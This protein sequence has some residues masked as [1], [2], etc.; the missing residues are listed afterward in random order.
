MHLQPLPLRLDWKFISWHHLLINPEIK[1]I[2][3]LLWGHYLKKF[4]TWNHQCISHRCRNP[5]FVCFAIP[6]FC[7]SIKSNPHWLYSTYDSSP[8][9]GSYLMMLT[10]KS[11]LLSINSCYLPCDR[12]FPN[13]RT[14]WKILQLWY[15][16]AD[17]L[18]N[19][20]VS[21]L[22]LQ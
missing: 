8:Q 15:P 11:H 10:C 2:M 13:G 18:K 6:P 22:G 21:V 20:Y 9:F 19:T 3:T 7:L 16:C 17:L 5:C 1:F 4:A 12:V 14:A